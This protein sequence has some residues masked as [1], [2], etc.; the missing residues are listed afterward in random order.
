M[1]EHPS[2]RLRLPFTRQRLL[3]GY[4]TPLCRRLY[5]YWHVGLDL[6]AAGRERGVCAAGEGLVVAAGEDALYGFGVAVLYRGCV[7]VSGERRD[8]LARYFHLSAVSVQTGDAVSAG[9][10]LGR[11]GACGTGE[12]HL[13]LELDA[14]LS[15]PCRSPQIGA[16]HSFWLPA[17]ADTTV[18]PALWLFCGA[19]QRIDA[20]DTDPAWL[21]ETALLLARASAACYNE[22]TAKRGAQP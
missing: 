14:D 22:D 21:G 16:G 13:H 15:C 11:E 17:D 10:V 20:A 8:L 9:N 4:K 3:C 19:G 12:M 6:A 7:S 1:T 2:Q 5:G 18:D